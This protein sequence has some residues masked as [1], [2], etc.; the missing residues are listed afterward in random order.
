MDYAALKTVFRRSSTTFFNSSLFFPP[1]TRREVTVLYAFVRTAD[2]YVD[3]FPERP[4]EFLAFRRAYLDAVRNDGSNDPVIAPF[5]EMMQ[6]LKF[7]PE[8]VTAFLDA[9]EQDLWKRDYGTIEETIQYMRGS[10]EV[11]GMMMARIM[12]V[13]DEALPPAAMLGRA[14]Q[15]INFIRD[16]QEDLLLG[17]QYLPQD[18]MAAVGLPNLSE[19]SARE[20]PEA[21]EAFMQ[22]QFARYAAWQ[23]EAEA[24]FRFLSGRFR[25]AVGTASRM[26][27]YTADTIARDP[28][29]VYGWKVKPSRMRVIATALA[30]ALCPQRAKR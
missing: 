2:D 7:D 15:Y 6:R 9:M 26:Y 14:F 30:L 11:I 8:W 19:P 25:I 29:I 24:G 27:T 20:N 13:P 16:L 23:Q 10:A 12:R 1:D 28:F 5:V 18:E 17:R 22:S 21:F 4:E 3:S